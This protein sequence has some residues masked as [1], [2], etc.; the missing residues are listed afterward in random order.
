MKKLS[1]LLI[2]A[3]SSLFIIPVISSANEMEL[4]ISDDYIDLRFTAEYEKDFAGQLALMHADFDDID[5]NQLS[6]KF[7][8]EDKLGRFDVQMGAKAF[9]LDAEDETGYGIALALGAT[10]EIINKLVAGVEL[11]YSPSIITGGDF[12]NLFEVDARISYHLLEN[13]TFYIGYRKIEI[14]TDGGDVDVDVYDDPYVGVR[15]QF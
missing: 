5:S 8:T 2:I 1:T 10:T 12:D 6:Y 13:G 14:D 7:Y 3:A 15:F 4:S 9:W 11:N